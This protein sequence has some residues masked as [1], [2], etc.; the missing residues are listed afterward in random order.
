MANTY[1]NLQ[2]HLV[3]STKNRKEIIQDGFCED[4]YSYLGGIIRSEKGKMLSIGGTKNH[5][6]ILASFAKSA[7]LSNMLQQIKGGSSRWLNEQN[8][9]PYHFGWQ[10]GYG[11][12]TV[13]ESMV[14][15]VGKYIENQVAHHKKMTFEE[16]YVKLLKKHGIEYNNIS[17]INCLRP[18]GRFSWGYPLSSA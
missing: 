9:L 8:V 4:L 16:E 6:H 5:I 10:S 12:F 15:V 2:Y 1:T 14:H 11:A 7:T 17:G 3:F 18:K 13:S